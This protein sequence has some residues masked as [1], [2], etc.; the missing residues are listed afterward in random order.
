MDFMLYLIKTTIIIKLSVT[1]PFG[2]TAVHLTGSGT[3]KGYT[4]K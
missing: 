4:G 2:F 1:E 3:Y